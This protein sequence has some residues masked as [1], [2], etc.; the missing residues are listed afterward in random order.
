MNYP[1]TRKSNQVDDY[2]GVKIPDPYRH[3][4]DDRSLETEEWVKE[5][6]A[7]CEQYLNQVKGREEL[8]KQ[9]KDLMN[10]PSYTTPFKK[11][12]YYYFYH[13]EG[14]QN[15]FVIYRQ[16]S[17]DDPAE[18]FLDPNTLSDN[19]TT[20][21]HLSGFSDDA[22]FVTVFISEAGSD[23]QTI[24]VMNTET[25]EWL[26]DEIKWVKFSGAQW[27]DNGFY[28]SG[29]SKPDN[30]SSDKNQFHKVY[31]H[32]LGKSQENDQLIYEDKE[33][34][35]RFHTLSITKDKQFLILYISE[36]TSGNKIK[37][38]NRS[39]NGK[40]FTTIFDKDGYEMS[41]VDTK[42]DKLITMTN[43]QA[44]NSKAIILDPEDPEN[45]TDLIPEKEYPLEGIV[46]TNYGIIASY[47]KDCSTYVEELDENGKF[48][49]EIKFPTIGSIGIG[50]YE[51]RPEELF[52]S[53]SSYV[54]PTTIYSYKTKDGELKLFKSTPTTFTPE[55]YTVKQ[56]FVA[57]KDGT[58]VP[59]FMIHKKGLKYDGNRP[60]IV[61][62]YGGFNI[63]LTP[64]YN[65]ALVPFL[66]KDGIYV[67]TNLRG[68]GEYGE[69]WHEGGM[70]EKK[71][72]VFDDFISITEY[73]IA[74]NYTNP[75]KIAIN[76]GSNGGLLVGSIL[77]QRP[78]LIG[79]AIAEVGVLDMLR[80]HKFTIG[81]GWAV[82]YGSSDNKED[83][84][85]LIKYSPLH[86]IKEDFN[87]PPTMVMTA[88]HDDRVV[89]AHSFKFVATLQEK[90]QKKN[91]YLLRV[92]IDSG[93]GSSSRD[94]LIKN[95]KDRLS[96][97]FK[98]LG[99]ED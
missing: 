37:V 46:I 67:V 58:K 77:T 85:Y 33:N 92:D 75:K 80:F 20:S 90:A 78:D 61:Y 43:Y 48:K 52:F 27:I 70:K 86:N 89:P 71:Q 11:G 29:Y 1:K 31:Y 8:G 19:G 22:K 59:F 73:L 3:L 72:N 84:E 14:L 98:N 63:S 34:P 21:A 47:L 44:P 26:E 25:K 17:L 57:S 18:L 36:G 82:E 87:Y 2:F 96:F 91:P 9:L 83:F 7:Q 97:V 38:L 23:W 64:S 76:G 60:T 53:F 40:E 65:P 95:A 35:L 62:G 49:R 12:D 66:E 50:S 94:K 55:N 54:H 6:N 13:N 68:G 15:Q 79:A 88:D 16:K 45:Y 24:K 69:K 30:S 39:K 42:D 4:E 93:H 81:W 41:I 74:E 51:R 5:Q 56:I 99:M 10:Y 32:E 28:Y